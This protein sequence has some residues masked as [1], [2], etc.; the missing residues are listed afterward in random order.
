MRA[1]EPTLLSAR[2]SR[3]R[4]IVARIRDRVGAT[5]SIVK[6]ASQVVKDRAGWPMPMRH[7][8]LAIGRLESDFGVSGS[9]RMP[10][11]V[12]SFN[13]GALT[14]K[15]TAGSLTHGDNA[16]DGTPITL[17]FQAFHTMSEGFDAFR[18]VWTRGD[19]AGDK[20]IPHEP[21]VIDAASRGDALSVARTMYAHR[22]YT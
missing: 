20:S 17:D 10:G 1:I 7:M 3:A 21:T 12:P 4:S 9:W 11:G 13:W 18:K 16:A 19:V 14:G 6:E 8:A 22:Y 5:A 2:T 15:G